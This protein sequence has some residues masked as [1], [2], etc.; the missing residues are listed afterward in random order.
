MR[1]ALAL[2]LVAPLAMAAQVEEPPPCPHQFD[3]ASDALDCACS[4][5]AAQNGNLWGTDVYTADSALCPAALHAGVIDSPGGRISVRAAPGRDAYPG[6]DRNGLQ[7]APFGRFE[8]SIAFVYE[9][10]RR[11]RASLA[12]CPGNAA[13]LEIGASVTCLC[14]WSA[15]GEAAGTVWGTG[16]YTADSA[17]CRAA[18]HAGRIG[19][20]GGVIRA[21]ILP[22]RASYSAGEANGVGAEA[23]PAMDKSVGFEPVGR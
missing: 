1:S 5:E 23:W 7:S 17:L 13:A 12:A 9:R 11:N 19:Y 8:R 18:V 4:A 21:G 10:E 6:S 3:A 2:L 14:S 15:S 20:G 16:P 22:G